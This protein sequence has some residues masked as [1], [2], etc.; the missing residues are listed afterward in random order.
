MQA[1]CTCVSP[2]QSTRHDWIMHRNENC[3]LYLWPVFPFTFT[4]KDRQICPVR[5]M[6]ALRCFYSAAV[7][8]DVPCNTVTVL[9][10]FFDLLIMGELKI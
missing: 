5:V 8:S 7:A 10:G 9:L 2:A 1:A 3:H 6:S 4:I